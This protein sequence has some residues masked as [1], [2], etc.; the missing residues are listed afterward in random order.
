VT[1]LDTVAA[2]T[3]WSSLNYLRHAIVLAAWLTS[4]KAFSLFYA[5]G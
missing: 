5:L 3:R 1:R 4:L 2:A